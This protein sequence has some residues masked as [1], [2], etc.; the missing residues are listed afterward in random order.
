MQL[1]MQ[2]A[3]LISDKNFTEKQVGLLFL[4]F[5]LSQFLCMAPAGYF[6]DYSNRKIDWVI[7]A[8]IIISAITVFG[9]L[10]AEE[11]GKKALGGDRYRAGRCAGG[12]PSLWSYGN[13]D[14]P[15]FIRQ[16]S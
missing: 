13:G 14:G 15:S 11:G 10:T 2:A 6:L 3:Y 12:E 4:V 7:Y 9:T 8:S 1:N 5:G 16:H